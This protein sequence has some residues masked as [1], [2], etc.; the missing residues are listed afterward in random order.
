MS[1]KRS[2]VEVVVAYMG[3]NPG[4]TRSQVRKSLSRHGVTAAA[5]EA[6]AEKC[7]YL[8]GGGSP[9]SAPVSKTKAKPGRTMEDF[10]GRFDLHHKV[11]LKVDELLPADGEIY[12]EDA[13]FRD[14]CDIHPQHW[15]RISEDDRFSPNR[16]NCRQCN[17]WAPSRM[18][19]KMKHILG[20]A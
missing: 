18:V 3:R 10:K 4:R 15:R 19:P 1:T 17:V 2:V 13:E 7:G 5:V 11:A 8:F 14:L 20:L 9:W 12:Y 16:V 6:A